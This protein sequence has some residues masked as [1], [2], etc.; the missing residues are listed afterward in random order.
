MGDYEIRNSEG[1]VTGYIKPA[2]SESYSSDDDH[3]LGWLFFGCPFLAVFGAIGGALVAGAVTA[4]VCLIVS[5]VLKI[6]GDANHVEVFSYVGTGAGL[7]A[8]LGAVATFLWGVYDCLRS[9]SNRELI[10]TQ[11]IVVLVIIALLALIFFVMA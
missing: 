5:A 7:G 10:R 4:L 8:V 2:S 1:R 9:E 3:G 11:L 6:T